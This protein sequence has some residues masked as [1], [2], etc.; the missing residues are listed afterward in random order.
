M[1]TIDR[2][3]TLADH[4]GPSESRHHEVKAARRRTINDTVRTHGRE[5]EPKLDIDTHTFTTGRHSA[6]KHNQTYTRTP[7][8]RQRKATTRQQRMST[9]EEYHDNIFQG[10]S[11]RLI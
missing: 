8:P 5:L 4:I 6:H 2:R 11:F 3:Q 10:M 7:A 1:A 9:R